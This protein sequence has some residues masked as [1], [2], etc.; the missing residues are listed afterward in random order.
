M[1][2][3][4]E[5]VCGMLRKLAK[6]LEKNREMFRKFEIVCEMFSKKKQPW[7]IQG[8]NLRPWRYKHHNRPHGKVQNMSQIE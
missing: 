2:R 1:F 6:G 7:S 4:F 3:K 5:I 8:S